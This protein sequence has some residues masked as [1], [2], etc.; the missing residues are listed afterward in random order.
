MVSEE[1]KPQIIMFSG[2][3]SGRIY[4]VQIVNFNARDF[5]AKAAIQMIEDGIDLF[6]Q[7][8]NSPVSERVEMRRGLL[9]RARTN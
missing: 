9:M 1:L 2:K 5:N 3:N 7:Q 8:K 4:E 6:A